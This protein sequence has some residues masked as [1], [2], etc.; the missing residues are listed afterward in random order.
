M[1]ALR[2]P[3]DCLRAAQRA[4]DGL[5]KAVRTLEQQQQQP[6]VYDKARRRARNGAVC[7]APT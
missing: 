4:R 7:L 1:R 5:P 2:L 3:A 6:A